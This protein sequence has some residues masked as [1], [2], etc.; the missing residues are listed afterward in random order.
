MRA[1]TLLL[2][3]ILIPQAHAGEA[4][5]WFAGGC[6]WCMES[7]YEKREGVID[8]ISG[9]TGGTLQNPTYRGNHEG[10]FEAVEVTYDPDKVSYSELVDLFWTNVD[11]FDDRG[12]F[13][14]K[15]FEYRTALFPGNDEERAI[16]EASLKGV[17]ERFPEQKVATEIRDANRFWP[18]EEYHQDYYK[19]NPVRYKYYRWNCGRDQRL[20]EIWGEDA[21]GGK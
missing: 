8:V 21:R 9:F 1:L 4:K 20:E 15:G 12:Q 19:K 3:F 16:A 7:D 10:H 14:D 5:A 17:Q 18:V 11:P 2:F 13:C 6:F